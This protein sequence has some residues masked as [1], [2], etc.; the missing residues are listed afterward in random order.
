MSNAVHFVKKCS[1]L[2]AQLLPN[3]WCFL[4]A[5]ISWRKTSDRWVSSKASVF[6]IER[7]HSSY[8]RKLHFV[9]LI[10]FGLKLLLKLS[11][12]QGNHKFL[13]IRMALLLIWQKQTV[14]QTFFTFLGVHVTLWHPNLSEKVHTAVKL[15]WL[16]ISVLLLVFLKVYCCQYI[17]LHY[18]KHNFLFQSQCGRFS[19]NLWYQTVWFCTLQYTILCP[20]KTYRGVYVCIHTHT[21]THTHRE[22][23]SERERERER[24]S[25]Q[26]PCDQEK[27]S[28]C[29]NEFLQK[30]KHVQQTVRVGDYCYTELNA[31]F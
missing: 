4:K 16:H 30:H 24:E 9:E 21:H 26:T 5:A 12:S 27:T 10:R 7:L 31:P 1:W 13:L 14:P 19:D 6:E 2:D 29:V 3:W 25:E 28:L 20:R 15:T 23:A 22:R 18:G 17:Q 8:S 11:S